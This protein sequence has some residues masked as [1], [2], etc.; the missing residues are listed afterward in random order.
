MFERYSWWNDCVYKPQD[1][2]FNIKQDGK[3]TY[4]NNELVRE[5]KRNDIIFTDTSMQI[6]KANCR[7]YY[8]NVYD[9]NK[10]LIRNY[11]P[12][13]DEN[14]SPCLYDTV[15]KNYFYYN[16]KEL[17]YKQFEN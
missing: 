2:V 6:G 14:G 12:V 4:I 8:V 15:T 1:E 11:I 17:K 5:I 7:I 10:K 9:E 3:N 16:G 13:L